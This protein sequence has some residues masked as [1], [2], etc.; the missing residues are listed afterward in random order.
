MDSVPIIGAY[1]F[2]ASCHSSMLN[3]HVFTL[4]SR[5]VCF[6]YLQHSD[7]T[8]PY[9]RKVRV[10]SLTS[11]HLILI[12]LWSR[13]NGHLLVVP[14]QLLIA[15]C[16]AGSAASFFIMWG[17]N[18]SILF[19]FFFFLKK[20]K[21]KKNTTTKKNKKK[22]KLNKKKLMRTSFSTHFFFSDNLPQATEAIKP[23]LGEYYNYDSTVRAPIL[24]CR[25]LRLPKSRSISLQYMPYGDRSRNAHLWKMK[26]T[27][28]S[29]EISMGARWWSRRRPTDNL[30][31]SFILFY[32]ILCHVWSCV[33][34]LVPYLNFYEH[35]F[36]QM[37]NGP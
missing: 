3:G 21:K 6:T 28:C 5:I 10:L 19:F 9:Y 33:I 2:S 36:G 1:F 30:L 7:P 24:S 22:N 11:G 16:L 8:I 4:E 13:I 25:S 23:I 35:T 32:L 12:T 26:A 18:V 34:S 37:N 29:S 14:L 27:F 31:W 17:T 15:P 20:K